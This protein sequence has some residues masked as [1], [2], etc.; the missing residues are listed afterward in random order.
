MMIIYKQ[1]LHFIASR[2]VRIFI[3][4][5]NASIVAINLWL[6]VA[7]FEVKLSQMCSGCDGVGNRSI[8]VLY[9]CVRAQ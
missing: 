1:Q 8:N 6:R 9:T 4:T 7:C 3:P 2:T 5:I